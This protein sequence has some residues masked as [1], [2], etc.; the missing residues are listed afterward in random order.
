MAGFNIERKKWQMLNSGR[1]S[2]QSDQNIYGSSQV[3]LGHMTR[4]SKFCLQAGEAPVDPH[5]T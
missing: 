3:G 1:S 5:L 2:A 4:G